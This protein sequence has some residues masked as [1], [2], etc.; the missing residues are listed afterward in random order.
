MSVD[1]STTVA[2]GWDDV[3]FTHFAASNGSRQL[4]QAQ[5]FSVEWLTGGSETFAISSVED[6]ML[7]FPGKGGKVDG[8]GCEMA[9][10]ER[11]VVI[12]PPGAYRLMPSVGARAIVLSTGGDDVPSDRPRDPRVIAVGRR[13]SPRAQGPRIHRFDD[14][15]APAD[16]PR[17]KLLQS[18]T[19]SINLVEY[20]GARDRRLLSP[21]AHRDFEQGTLTVA[22]D[23]VHHLRKE[24][25]RD[26]SLWRQDQHVLAEGAALIVIPPEVIHTTEGVG[27][28]HHLLFDI[29]A[30]PR[31]DFIAK[32]WVFN[33]AD[34][35]AVD[36]PPTA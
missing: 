13:F 36:A 2:T 14:L 28:G 10:P 33:A 7:L 16:N 34:Y 5:N 8:G 26:A 29:F 21:H 30:P 23:F 27:N 6:I 19:M 22:G 12:L 15:V 31:A 24:W 1:Q 17:L 18:T 32:G 4:V 20:E 3:T 9:L 35:D 25:G 11:C